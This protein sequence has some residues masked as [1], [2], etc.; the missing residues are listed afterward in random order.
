MLG[1][2]DKWY[3]MEGVAMDTDDVGTW[4]PCVVLLAP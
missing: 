2:C 1:L 3:V 4:P